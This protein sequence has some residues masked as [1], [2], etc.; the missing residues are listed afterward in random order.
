MSNEYFLRRSSLYMFFTFAT[1]TASMGSASGMAWLLDREHA[2]QTISNAI[3]S[4]TGDAIGTVSDS[5]TSEQNDG[6]HLHLEILDDKGNYV[7]PLTLLPEG[8]DK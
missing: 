8:T 5:M 1:L 3:C 7:D 2:E 4:M 6:A